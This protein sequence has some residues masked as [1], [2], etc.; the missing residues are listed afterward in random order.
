ME[1]SIAQLL[2][3]SRRQGHI[4]QKAKAWPTGM[5]LGHSARALFNTAT[6]DAA[7]A[8]WDTMPPDQLPLLAA[9]PSVQ[10]SNEGTGD[11]VNPKDLAALI[12][13]AAILTLAKG[14]LLP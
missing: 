8:S 13:A 10:Y 2:R 1:T 14:D 11:R 5:P 12:K 6:L 3:M 7:Q 4:L 9:D